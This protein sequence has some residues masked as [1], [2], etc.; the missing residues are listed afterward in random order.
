[1]AGGSSRGAGRQAFRSGGVNGEF[2]LVF[3]PVRDHEEKRLARGAKAVIQ[4]QGILKYRAARGS[5]ESSL[6]AALSE[7]PDFQ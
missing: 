5:L 4:R 6:A 3:V 7:L 2:Q 1:L